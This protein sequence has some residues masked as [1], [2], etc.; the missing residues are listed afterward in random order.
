[1][2]RTGDGDG[3]AGVR[4]PHRLL[5]GEC[6]TGPSRGPHAHFQGDP[7]RNF[8]LEVDLKPSRDHVPA[9]AEQIPPADTYGVGHIG[10]A[11]RE[12]HFGDTEVVDVEGMK[13]DGRDDGLAETVSSP[14]WFGTGG[15]HEQW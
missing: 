9:R 8:A 15:T 7:R 13:L 1:M 11:R 6:A 2:H 14:G 3:I 12:E 5:E 10:V 4:P